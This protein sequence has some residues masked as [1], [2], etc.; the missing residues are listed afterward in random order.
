[1]T[2][3]LDKGTH[4]SQHGLH[5]RTRHGLLPDPIRD[6]RPQSQAIKRRRFVVQI[7]HESQS[8]LF[9]ERPQVFEQEIKGGDIVEGQ[10]RGTTRG[11]GSGRGIDT[12]ADIHEISIELHHH[13][14]LCLLHRF[15]LI[16]IRVVSLRIEIRQ[17]R[18]N[19]FKNFIENGGIDEPITNGIPPCR[20][21]I[22]PKIIRG[23]YLHGAIG[24]TRQEG[25]NVTP[26]PS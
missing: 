14:S 12:A 11:S 1:M 7:R 26:P 24:E 21:E 2:F 22:L 6:S 23:V 18:S 8:S 13:E 9:E 15:L 19:Q 5:P 3:H 10:G 4:G 16:R 17:N 20:V 25:P